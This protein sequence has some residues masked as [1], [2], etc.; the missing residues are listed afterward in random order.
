MAWNEPSGN[1]KNPW[2]NKGG[3]KR[4]DSG[5][6][7]LD[8]LMQKM[9]GGL[10]S[11]F[12]KGAGGDGRNIMFVWGG[13]L[14]ALL[15][16]LSTGF[17]VIDEQE[18]GIVLRF[19]AHVDTLSPGL[20]WR[21]PKPVENVIKINVEQTRTFTHKASMLT[22]DT[23]IVDVEVAVQWRVNDPVK[24]KFN[25]VDSA[26][27][28]RQVSESAVREVVGGNSLDDIISK[29]RREIQ[30][31]Q[32]ELI[33]EIIDRYH[34]GILIIDVNMRQAKPP[35]AVA[36]AF[37]DAVK[38]GEDENKYVNQAEAYRNDI[39]P[40]ARG[41]AARLRE[42][43]NAYRARVIARSEGEAQRFEQ[44]LAE[45]DKAP[46]VTRQRLYLDAIESVLSKTGKVLLDADQGNSLIYLPIDKLMRQNQNET[47]K[48]NTGAA[49][50]G[51]DARPGV[52][53]NISTNSGN[54]SR[55]Q[56]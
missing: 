16:W 17:Y 20:R 48:A 46:L 34:A 5:P 21:F 1:G 40:K 3:K 19:G 53:E 52:S 50:S 7:D 39:I 54:R 44:L 45:Y 55:G 41:A 22:K 13:L 15:A 6:P 47:G 38:A 26:L 25:V 9:Q 42:E 43:A 23:N 10:G 29:G 30:V 27:T 11:L 31:Q 12:G 8:E 4:G 24:F 36:D 37:D 14:L 51:F 56:R 18:K 28:L 49:A 33:Q 32:M 35:A 2:D